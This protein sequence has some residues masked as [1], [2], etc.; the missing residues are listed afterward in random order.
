MV[1]NRE[2][3]AQNAHTCRREEADVLKPS[4]CSA[5]AMTVFGLLYIG[6]IAH[7]YGLCIMIKSRFYCFIEGRRLMRYNSL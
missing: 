6:T 1:A 3:S 7:R 4:T 2:R 5:V